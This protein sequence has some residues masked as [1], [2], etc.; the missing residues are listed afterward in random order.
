MIEP[1]GRFVDSRHLSLEIC[2]L[3][4]ICFRRLVFKCIHLVRIFYPIDK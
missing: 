4:A 1:K 3:L 2:V